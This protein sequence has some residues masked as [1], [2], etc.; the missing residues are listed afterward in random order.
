MQAATATIWF[1]A[2]CIQDWDE[3]GRK[4]SEKYPNY[5]RFHIFMRERIQKRECSVE[6]MKSVTREI[7][8]ETFQCNRFNH[9][10]II[11]K[12]VKL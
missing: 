7:E 6:K 3:S 11:K 9:T 12:K 10:Y 4:R 2:M 8:I 5:F 1:V